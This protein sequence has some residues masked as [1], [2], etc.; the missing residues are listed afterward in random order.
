M[1]LTEWLQRWWRARVLLKKRIAEPVWRRVVADVPVIARLSSADQH[2]LRKLS[3]FFLHQKVIVGAAGMELD[4]Y[5]RA[6]I[7]AQASLLVLNLGLEYYAG[8]VEIIVYP[9]AF[10]VSHG[11]QDDAGVMHHSRRALSG[12]AWGRGPVIL[13]WEDI[14][15]K[16]YA[17]H[18]HGLNVVLHEFA[19]KL[20]LLDG[21]ANGMPPLHSSMPPQQWS[22]D[23]TRAYHRMLSHLDHGHRS[24]IDPYAIESP[25]EFFAVVSEFF[26]EKPELLQEELPAVY[27]EL[28]AF[29]R[30]DPLQY[31]AS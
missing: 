6:V 21:S 22:D 1:R 26:F 18:G 7:A 23:F 19:H 24:R 31:S 2:R 5:M 15:P 20:D 8:W 27:A 3:S 25:A 12:E 13:S 16:P 14:R 9:D 30:Q 17:A 10:I 29:Y 28:V 11:Q 4:E